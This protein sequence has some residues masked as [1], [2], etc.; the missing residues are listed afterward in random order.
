MYGVISSE[1]RPEGIGAFYFAAWGVEKHRS[2]E[3]VENWVMA[4]RRGHPMIRAWKRVFNSY[5]SSKTR[6]DA[7]S[8]FLDPVGVP[9]HPLFWG[10][11]LGHLQS[12]GM[13]LRNYLVMHA[14]FKKLIDQD[15]EMR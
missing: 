15:P 12:Y 5:W 2:A 3:Y 1:H 10:V 9:E 14:A 8:V 13:D 11:D 6:V 4:A 7:M